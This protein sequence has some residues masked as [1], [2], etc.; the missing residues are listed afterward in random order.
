MKRSDVIKGVMASDAKKI[1]YTYEHL[2]FD[3]F[4][5]AVKMIGKGRNIYVV[6][7]RGCAPLASYLAFHLNL[8]V[9]GVKLLVTNSASELF[10]QM[11][12]INEKDVLIA[13][14]F[15]R[16]SMRTLKATEFANQR[17]AKVITITD[18]EHSPINLYSSCKLI[19]KSDMTDIADSLVAPMSLV[20][21]LVV[22]LC[23]HKKKRVLGTLESL[24]EIWEDYQIY[25][26]DELN[27]LEEEPKIK[28]VEGP[29][30]R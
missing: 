25:G 18:E 8:A 16:Y 14:S 5:E 26:P 27:P 4:D 19:A 3:A 1:K 21:A 29:K 11:L 17:K 9:P 23:R 6:G 24:E 7:L 22:A 15:P 30:E 13:V 12:Y 28:I 10:E 20:N 2:D